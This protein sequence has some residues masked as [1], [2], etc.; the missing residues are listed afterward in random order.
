MVNT[1]RGAVCGE[2]E[3]IEGLREGRIAGARLGVAAGERMA[4]DFALW[5]LDIV[6]AHAACGATGY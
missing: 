3:R 4:A 5:E 2:A 1:S 6:V